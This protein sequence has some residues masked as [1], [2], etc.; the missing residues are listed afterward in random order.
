MRDTR[1]NVKTAKSFASDVRGIIPYIT[2]NNGRNLTKKDPRNTLNVGVH[3]A[4]MQGKMASKEIIDPVSGLIVEKRTMKSCSTSVLMNDRCMDRINDAIANNDDECIC[5]Y[6]FSITA[7]SADTD[8]AKGMNKNCINNHKLLTS[9]F[10]G[11]SYIP[12]IRTTDFRFESHADINNVIQGINYIMLIEKSNELAY[13]ENR[14]RT[15]FGIWTKNIDIWNEVFKIVGKPDNVCFHVSS[16]K[17]N[18][19]LVVDPVEY[20]FVDDVFTVWDSEEKANENNVELTCCRLG[21]HPVC[22]ICHRCYNGYHDKITY[23]DELLRV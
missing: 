14:P 13:M 21:Y 17:K 5:L 16:H 4:D 10:M 11:W 20:W 2:N 22:V 8:T 12:A 7:V 6:C 3:F 9:M 23:T 1:T 18:T 15:N 19:R